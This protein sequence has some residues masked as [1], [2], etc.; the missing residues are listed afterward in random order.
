MQDPC[1]MLFQLSVHCL[2]TQKT[3]LHY[4]LCDSGTWPLA[5]LS[6]VDLTLLSF[7]NRE[8]WRGIS[9]K[10]FY[11]W[12][13]GVSVLVSSCWCCIAESFPEHVVPQ[14]ACSTSSGLVTPL[15]WPYTTGTWCS[16]GLIPPC[17]KGV[18]PACP[19]AVDQLWF[20][21]PNILFHHPLDCSHTF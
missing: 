7:V 19:V 4:L 12:L 16:P 2:T 5:H 13:N 11:S 3:T 15:L 8:C 9:E 18:F 21:W 17:W 1:S 14:G 6:F 10:E 20:E